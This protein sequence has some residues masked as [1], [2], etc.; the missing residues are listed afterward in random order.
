MFWSSK[1]AWQREEV[2]RGWLDYR[3]PVCGLWEGSDFDFSE[4][5]LG[6]FEQRNDRILHIF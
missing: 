1:G 2:W 3:G 6:D 4:G 5:S